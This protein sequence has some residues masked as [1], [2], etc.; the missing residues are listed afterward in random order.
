[1]PDHQQVQSYYDEQYYGR[2]LGQGESKLPWHMRRVARRLDP[3]KG[4]TA[5][6]VACGTGDWLHELRN[7]GAIVS[8]IDISTRAAEI[9]R[10]RLSGADIRTG[11]AE[12]L[13]FADRQF[14]LV[15]CMGSLEHF[16]DQ[17]GAL[18]EMRRVAKPDASFLILVPNAGFLTRRLGLYSG[19][20]QVAIRETVRSIAEWTDMFR[21]VGLQVDARWRD[22]HPL[23]RHWICHGPIWAWPVRFVQAGALA[24]WP[25]RWQYQVYFLCRP[26]GFEAHA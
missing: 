23:S 14:D 6:D 9:A 12:Q 1:M 18:R 3:L 24:L 8:G 22:L 26:F 11:V 16:L 25:V 4:K 20:G 13:P 7:Q 19:T 17:P 5:L 10:E 2:V 21:A 15:T